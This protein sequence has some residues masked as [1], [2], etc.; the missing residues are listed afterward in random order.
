MHATEAIEAAKQ[1]D[2]SNTEA[3]MVKMWEAA[4]IRKEKIE[5]ERKKQKK[6]REVKEKKAAEEKKI[7]EMR[8]DVHKRAEEAEQKKIEEEKEKVP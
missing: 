8:E 1:S 3:H 6:L 2:R 4:R 5:A 7:V